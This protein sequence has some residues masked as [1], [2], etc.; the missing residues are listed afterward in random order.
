MSLWLIGFAAALA[1]VLIVALLLIGILWQ[2]LRIKRLAIAASGIVLQI[3]KN[4]QSVWALRTTN[5]VA[6][7][8]LAGATAIDDNARAIVDAA[9]HAPTS[10]DLVRG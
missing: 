8:I 3:D 10:P 6:A 2:A 9:S 1:V 7:S 4:T 5:E